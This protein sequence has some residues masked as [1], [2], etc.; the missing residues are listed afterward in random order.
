MLQ[1][2]LR[3][4]SL[5]EIYNK[6]HS[7]VDTVPAD[8]ASWVVKPVEIDDVPIV[9][10]SLWSERPGGIDDHALRRIAE[11]ME[12]ALQS[13]PDTNRTRI[14]SGRPRVVRVELDTAAMSARRTSSGDI[15]QALKLSNVRLQAGRFDRANTGFLV[16]AGGFFDSVEELELAAVN[17]VDGVPVLL[18]DVARVVDGP[19]EPDSYSWIGFGP[20]AEA[21]AGN[22]ERTFFPAVHIAIAKQAGA[23]AVDVSDRIKHRVGELAKTHFPDGVNYR[24]TRDSGETAN[25]KVNELLEAL[26]VAILIVVVLIAFILGWREGRDGIDDED[27][28]HEEGLVGVGDLEGAIRIE[29]RVHEFH[30]ELSIGKALVLFRDGAESRGRD[31]D[32]RSRA[33]SCSAPSRIGSAS[34]PYCGAS[35]R[36]KRC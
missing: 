8:V 31:R 35:S 15:V 34:G 24:I 13:I 27:V 16:E 12:I 3:Y 6:L 23:N 11:E 18:K 33:R 28:L 10:V 4:T 5:Q 21:G 29:H 36:P 32:S 30:L 22:D 26:A 7:N 9:I 2:Q 1:V 20:A 17:V 19:A 14:S 25:E